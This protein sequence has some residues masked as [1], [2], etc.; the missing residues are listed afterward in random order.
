MRLTSKPRPDYGH[1][2]QEDW[3]IYPWRDSPKNIIVILSTK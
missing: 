3:P 1:N 2:L